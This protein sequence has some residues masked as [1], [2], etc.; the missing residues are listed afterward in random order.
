MGTGIIGNDGDM[1]VG[2]GII[3]NDRNDGHMGVGS[4]DNGFVCIIGDSM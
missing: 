2:T 3:G 4:S 1:G